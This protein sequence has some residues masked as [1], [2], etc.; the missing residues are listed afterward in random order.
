VLRRRYRPHC[1]QAKPFAEPRARREQISVRALPSPW[2]GGSKFPFELSRARGSGSCYANRARGGFSR[3]FN[4]GTHHI[5]G[6]QRPSPS[7]GLGGSRFPLELSRARGSAGASFHLSSPEPVARALAMPIELLA[8]SAGTSTS[9]L[10]H[11]RQAR[12]F[13]EPRAR[14]EQIS[15]RALPSPW[16]VLYPHVVVE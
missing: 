14:R 8:G 9:V 1:R 15:V 12:A 5:V 13:A 3:C 4:V 6:R 7:R 10:L 16:H 11:R 2:L